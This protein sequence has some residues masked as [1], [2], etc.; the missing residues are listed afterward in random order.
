MSIPTTP[1][2]I[3]TPTLLEEYN[4]DQK[5]YDSVI[6]DGVVTDLTLEQETVTGNE[7]FYK[8]IL[9]HVT[10]QD[11][12]DVSG[13][14]SFMDTL[15]KGAANVTQA[16]KDFFKWL[17]SFF[18][19]K[20][21]IAI[22][23]AETLVLNIDK[24][25]VSTNEIPYPSNY[26]DIYNKVGIPANNLGWMPGALEECGKA[27]GRV[28]SYCAEV[29]KA[30]TGFSGKATVE[31][32]K[33]KTRTFVAGAQHALGI[34]KL[35]DPA[36]FFGLVDVQMDN[37]GKLKELPDPPNSAKDPKFRTD[38]T[39]VLGLLKQ[40]K[41]LVSAAEKMV[42]NSSR[43]EKTFIKA[44]NKSFDEAKASDQSAGGSYSKAVGEVQEVVRYAMANL[45]MMETAVFKAI[46]GSIS[47]LSATANKG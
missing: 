3:N 30:V 7:V 5:G 2:S 31:E 17:F 46:A 20:K 35:N 14:E 16:V 4:A 44:L 33:E 36:K 24:H 34:P 23:K 11:T 37:D 41:E 15:K 19:G 18:T 40:H 25:G 10:P 28:N 13:N 9:G 42:E 12:P 38:Q 21:E 39:Q 22:R 43:L 29:E 8:A 1:R 47:I 32:L 27:I 6:S 26:T 45:K